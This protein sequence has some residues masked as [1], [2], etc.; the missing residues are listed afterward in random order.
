MNLYATNLNITLLVII[1]LGLFLVLIIVI[2]VILISKNRYKKI[3]KDFIKKVDDL[4][5]FALEQFNGQLNRLKSISELNQDYEELYT[6]YKISRDAIVNKYKF[7]LEQIN[8]KLNEFSTQKKAKK[9]KECLKAGND[10]YKSYKIEIDELDNDLQNRLQ[11]SDEC[12]DSCLKYKAKY[13]EIKQKYIDN[14]EALYL[15]DKS[16]SDVFKIIEEKFAYFDEQVN[17]AHYDKAREI[18]ASLN[19]DKVLSQLENAVNIMPEYCIKI[20][21]VIPEKIDK[22]KER[23]QNLC[24]QGYPLHHLKFSNT[25]TEIEDIINSIKTR[26]SNFS[27][28]NVSYEINEINEKLSLIEQAFIDEEK[29]KKYFDDKIDEVYKSSKEVDRRYTK[30]KRSIS[31]LK[32]AYELKA[33]YIDAISSLQDKIA[34]LYKIRREIETFMHSAT[35]QPY[36]LMKSKLDELIM[37]TK[38]IEEI[39]NKFQQYIRSLK[40]DAEI[41]YDRL[42]FS[43]LNLK[44]LELK[45]HEM[46]LPRYEE[47]LKSQFKNGYRILDGLGTFI[48]LKPLN[49][50]SLNKSVSNINEI[51]TSL[52]KEIETNYKAMKDAEDAIVLGNRYREDFY[53]VRQSLNKAEEYFYNISFSEAFKEAI[54]ASKR[55]SPNLGQND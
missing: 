48:F 16:F 7:K 14:K 37:Q 26:L 27:Y 50:E 40:N 52:S 45:L 34:A 3:T 32:E 22:L 44:K 18:I 8:K 1:V 12:R 38:E 28:R 11:E 21:K 55:V 31:E 29:A 35:R 49:V 51:E 17:S 54:E 4:N 42:Y 9:I 13:R 15:C 2:Y 33:T 20:D 5:D 6:R 30:I 41:A 47:S 24:D 36:F 53:D 25:M 39:E 43:F 19:L 10:V 23:Y 46:N